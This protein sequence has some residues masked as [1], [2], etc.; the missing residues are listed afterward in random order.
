MATKAE[1]QSD[2]DALG[3]V[4]DALSKLQVAGQQW[5]LDTAA[6]RLHISVPSAGQRL[7]NLPPSDSGAT[8]PANT[9]LGDL[10]P[11]EFVKHKAPNSDV[12]RVACLAFYLTNVRQTPAYAARDLSTLNTEA[13]GPRFNMSRALDNATRL[14]CYLTSAGKGKKQITTLGEDVVEALPDYAK[15]AEV[16]SAAKAT[17]RRK[18]GKKKKA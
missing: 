2:V 13:A 4:L 9:N 7:K 15:V 3:T 16:L 17:K 14:S 12:D 1:Y 11:K 18:A 8:P 5:V 6:A 10:K